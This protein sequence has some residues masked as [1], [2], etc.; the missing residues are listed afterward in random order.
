MKK[1]TGL[2]I[3][4]LAFTTVFTFSFDSV[5][6]KKAGTSKVQ[7]NAIKIKLINSYVD[8]NTS[9]IVIRIKNKNSKTIQ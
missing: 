1:I 7:S 4:L 8:T 3:F 2:I 5:K 6:A 9:E